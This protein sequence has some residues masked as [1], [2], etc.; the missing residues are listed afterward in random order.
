MRKYDKFGWDRMD[1]AM[2]RLIRIDWLAALQDYPLDEVREACRLH[3]IEQPNKVP[4][5][6]HIRAIV[7]R[8]RGKVV[9]AAP[10]NTPREE[11]KPP[12]SDEEKAR[13]AQMV[14]EAGFAKRVV[15]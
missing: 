11:E 15:Q 9:A 4:N 14:A 6:G 12:R 1:E 13:V 5:E 8:E 2:R 7:V 3:T 10:K